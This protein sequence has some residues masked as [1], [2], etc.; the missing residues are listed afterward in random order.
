MNNHVAKLFFTETATKT[1]MIL[2]F[3]EITTKAS[4]DY[5][6]IIRDTI[7]KIGYNDSNIGNHLSTKP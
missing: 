3:G 5:Q 6:K 7:Q 4:L 1:G 2:V